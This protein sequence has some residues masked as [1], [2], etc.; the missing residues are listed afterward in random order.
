MDLLVQNWIPVRPLMEGAPTTISLQTLLCSADQ[1]TL[2]LP[3]DDMELSALQLLICLTQV[4]WTPEDAQ[5]LRLRISQP[6]TP[7]A[8]AQGIVAWGD[9]FQLDHPE[10]PFMQV[11]GVSAKDVTSM[12]KLLAG[13]T[14]ATN[15]TF[16]NEPEQ[17]RALCGG[18]AA[19]ALFNQAN[20]AP[21]FGGG[22]KSGLR[23]GAPVTTLLQAVD[24]RRADLRT[25][26]WLN[27]LTQ[28]Y[29]YQLFGKDLQLQ[30]PPVWRELIQAGATIP[31]AR[32]GLLR[33]LF[34]QPAH[35][36]LCPPVG[37]GQCSGCGQQ[38]PQRYIGFLKEK[39]TFTVEGVWPHPHSPRV[40]QVKKGEVEDKFLA[41]TTSAPSWTQIS[42]L[43]VSRDGDKNR[44]SVGQSPAAVVEQNRTVFPNARLQLI[45]GGYRN[46]QA[47]ILERRHEVL[48]VN[49]GWQTHPDVIDEVI[50]IGLD[51]KT[52]LRNALYTFAEGIKNSDVKGAGMAVH[53]RGTCEYYRQSDLLISDLLASIDFAHADE[54][55]DQLT[56]ALQSLCVCLFEQV[57][58]PYYH[59]PKL[60]RS[61]A[62]SRRSLH[63]HLAALK[64]TQGG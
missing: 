39:F 9:I 29:L 36:E 35:I 50:R 18:C 33:G 8:F 56:L 2:C 5:T 20:N 28:P 4:I 57:T 27:I 16:I 34:W 47:S 43:L 25:T 6:L 41:F 13:L 42:R 3:R 1:W 60:V 55:L 40:L 21:S 10:M 15:C 31:A 7:D 24:N 49:Q 17:G 38:A 63:K 53:E 32:I 58:A 46:N 37:I 19:I 11:K 26:I 30:Q 44:N 22:F 61:L 14:G 12:D 62:I 23:G 51:H 59:H 52:V 54:H 45:I 48:V 64:Q